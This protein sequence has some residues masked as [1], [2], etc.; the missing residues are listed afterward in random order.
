MKDVESGKCTQAVQRPYLNI[1]KAAG[2]PCHELTSRDNLTTL[3]NRLTLR[4]EVF[5]S[6]RPPP[7]GIQ[8]TAQHENYLKTIVPIRS[9]KV[10]PLYPKQLYRSV[11][12]G[13]TAPK[14]TT[15]VCSVHNLPPP[16]E[17]LV[18]YQPHRQTVMPGQ[19]SI[20]ETF[21]DWT[22]A[23]SRHRYGFITKICWECK[24][25][26]Y[27][28]PPPLLESAWCWANSSTCWFPSTVFQSLIQLHRPEV[29]CLSLSI[30]PPCIRSHW[31]FK[32]LRYSLIDFN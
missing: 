28:R 14:S 23:E 19:K 3:M 17:L 18:C 15:K 26:L 2:S 12:Y 25:I 7:R 29:A 27:L 16:S 20:Y 8:Y 24:S 1:F 6:L 13:A 9:I 32:F 22:R 11:Q 4:I 30:L 5:P 21:L 31:N 10:S